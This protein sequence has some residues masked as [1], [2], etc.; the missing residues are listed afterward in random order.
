MAKPEGET[1]CAKVTDKA[2]SGQHD[3]SEGGM[4]GKQIGVSGEACAV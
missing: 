3:V 4:F 1:E 2:T